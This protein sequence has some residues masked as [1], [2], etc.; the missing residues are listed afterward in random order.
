MKKI[1]IVDD[2]TDILEALALLLNLEGYNVKTVDNGYFLTNAVKLFK[3][4]V[5]LLDV[6]L[7]LLD[8]R[9]L[10]DE[11]KHMSET[12]HIPIIMIS[13]THDLSSLTTGSCGANDFLPKPFNIDQLLEKVSFQLAS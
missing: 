11:L 1:L 5:I 3:P 8:G 7:G 10:C 13:A 6:M 2:S 4:D 9:K 12:A